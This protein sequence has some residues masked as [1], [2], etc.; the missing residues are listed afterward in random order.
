MPRGK[1]YVPPVNQE[2]FYSDKSTKKTRFNPNRDY[3]EKAVDDYLNE[4]GK[5][6][7][8]IIDKDTP[9]LFTPFNDCKN[10]DEFLL[11]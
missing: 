3:V 1:D 8:I 7:Q 5:I 4:G 6:T 9:L 11:G 2:K 10:V